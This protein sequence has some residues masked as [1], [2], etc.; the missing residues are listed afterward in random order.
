MTS[1]N[2]LPT[3]DTTYCQWQMRRPGWGRSGHPAEVTELW[4][5]R[6]GVTPRNRL[7]RVAARAFAI[8][9]WLNLSL[10]W[11]SFLNQAKGHISGILLVGFRQGRVFMG[12]CPL[13]HVL[14][15]TWTNCGPWA[16]AVSRSPAGLERDQLTRDA[17]SNRWPGIRGPWGLLPFPPR[18]HW[19]PSFGWPLSLCFLQPSCSQGPFHMRST[20]GNVV[21]SLLAALITSLGLGIL[22]LS[23]LPHGH[24]HC[25]CSLL[26]HTWAPGGVRLGGCPPEVSPRGPQGR[27]SQSTSIYKVGGVGQWCK[28]F[29]FPWNSILFLLKNVLHRRGHTLR[30]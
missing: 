26:P 10:H 4:G 3:S 27:A 11:P 2:S 30:C 5:Q 24:V 16:A 1:L 21:S 8:C 7:A 29:F 9:P 25:S 13:K 14:S 19:A 17:S 23:S 12:G 28:L 18:T 20:A 22:P 15:G 6:W